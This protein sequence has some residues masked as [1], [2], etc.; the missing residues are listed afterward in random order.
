MQAYLPNSDSDCEEV[1]A[2][3]GVKLGTSSFIFFRA[4]GLEEQTL[5]RK[6]AM[7]T[8]CLVD[9][10]LQ[11]TSSQ[12]Y[13]QDTS[14]YE[15]PKSFSSSM[16]WRKGFSEILKCS[17]GKSLNYRIHLG[18]QDRLNWFFKQSKCNT[19][20]ERVK[21]EGEVFND[22]LRTLRLYDLCVLRWS[23]VSV[24]SVSSLLV[25]SSWTEPSCS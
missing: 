10:H 23:A 6:T 16:Q 17:R 1:V 9:L 22:N 8:T 3:R 4:L 19:R 24:V 2:S 13:I 14:T 11:I 12:W 18:L 25:F 21:R 15:K 20:W 7:L 5:K